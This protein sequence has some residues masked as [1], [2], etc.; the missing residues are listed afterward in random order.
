MQCS[1]R[2]KSLI[3]INLFVLR[4]IN[5][6]VGIK[7]NWRSVKLWNEWPYFTI[8][9]FRRRQLAEHENNWI[10]NKLFTFWHSQWWILLMKRHTIEDRESSDCAINFSRWCLFS[11]FYVKKC[12]AHIKR[13]SAGRTDLESLWVQL[14]WAV[15]SYDHL[16]FEHACYLQGNRNKFVLKKFAVSLTM[17]T[18][19]YRKE[20]F[21]CIRQFCFHFN[22]QNNPAS[23]TQKHHYSVHSNV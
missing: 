17:G 14:I 23:P 9:N 18:N 2:W 19:E 8:F 4:Q 15:S 13:N 1:T 22:P 7:N 3:F 21:I 11:S 16:Q 5:K 12:I 20:L 6:N 10:A